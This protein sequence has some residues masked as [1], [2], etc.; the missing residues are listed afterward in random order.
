MKTFL[1]VL[2]SILPMIFINAQENHSCCDEDAVTK[3][4]R[5]GNDKN[6]VAV[7][8]EPGG[9]KLTNPAG[10]MITFNTPD[11]KTGNG[12]EVK[13]STPTNKYLLVFHEWYGLNDYIKQECESWAADLGVNVIG[14]D[15]YDGKV[16]KNNQEASQYVQSVETERGLNVIAGA[17]DYAPADAIFGTIGWCFGGGWSCQ[18]A[19]LL[20]DRCK[21]CVMYYG[22]PEENLDRLAKL[23][24]PVYGIF[25]LQDAHINQDIVK[26][27][28]A[29][30]NSLGKKITTKSY[31]AVHGFANPSNP[32]HDAAATADARALV[33]AF[34]NENFK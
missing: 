34:F 2:F 25:A 23:T 14:V 21:A 10:T 15:L 31:D 7:H 11:G 20:G 8:N 12:Y 9:F 6:F 19:I 17:R 1:I 29:N 27:F 32:K 28:E 22:M 18:A 33:T 16:A 5:L 24:A 30:M 26:K 4:S 3:F 13:A